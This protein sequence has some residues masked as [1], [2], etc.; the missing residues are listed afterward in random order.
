LVNKES[1]WQLLKFLWPSLSEKDIPHHTKIHQEIHLRAH[2]TEEKVCQALANVKGKVSFTFNTW[3][4]DAKD[5]Y[6]SI[7]AHY[8]TA[9]E[10]QP[11]EWE[12][13]SEQLAFMHFK[14]N[15]SGVNMANTL[16]CT[17]NHYDLQKKVYSNSCWVGFI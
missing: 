10:G 8:I 12:L 15:H 11:Q 4:S 3:T 5:P 2:T 6:I 13:K 16:I 14:G 9:P 17:I 1:F 7:T